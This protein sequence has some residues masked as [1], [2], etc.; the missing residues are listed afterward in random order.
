MRCNQCG[1]IMVPDP[2]T[3]VPALGCV[4]CGRL[5]PVTN[6]PRIGRKHSKADLNRALRASRRLQ[7]RRTT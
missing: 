1:G 6:A 5:V 3:L 4:D 2:T 7:A